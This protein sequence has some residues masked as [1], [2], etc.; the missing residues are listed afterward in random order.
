[1][2][3]T[4][5]S[6][7]FAYQR[8]ATAFHLKKIEL[9]NA[10]VLINSPVGAKKLPFIVNWFGIIAPKDAQLLRSRFETILARLILLIW[11]LSSLEVNAQIPSFSEIK[12]VFPDKGAGHLDH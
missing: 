12:I 1:M 5:L 11:L 10:R 6:T 4:N 8:L 3:Y 9:S 7:I 2:R